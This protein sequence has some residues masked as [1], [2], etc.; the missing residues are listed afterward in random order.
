MKK[1]LTVNLN[2]I[3]FHIDNDAYDALYNY[4][5]EVENRLSEA[6]RKEVMADIE[7]R[8][9]ELFTEKLSKGKHVVTIDDVDLVISVLGKPNQFASE[10]TDNE[11]EEEPVSNH[12]PPSKKSTRK[13]YRDEDNAVLGGIAAG[14]AAYL[15]WDVATIRIILVV[16]LFLSYSTLIPVYIIVW[17]IAPAARTVAQKLEMQGEPVTAERIK[18]EINSMKNYVNS[19]EF[20][21]RS[22]SFGNRLG[23]VLRPLIKIFLGVVGTIMGFV[24]FAVLSALLFALSLMIFSPAILSGFFPEFGTLTTMLIVSILLMI[25]IPV[26]VLIFGA[27]RIISGKRS[28]NKRF[29][30]L[31]LVLW[32]IGIFLFAGM[33]GKAVVSV[34]RGDASNFSFYWDSNTYET[35][36][37]RN[38][39][40][41]DF[42]SLDV[43]GNVK[44]YLI[45]DSA[46]SL[47]ATGSTTAL[48]HLKTGLKDGV[49]KISTEKFHVNRELK[50]L[51]F[52][53]EIH[54][55]KMSG[56]STL[57]GQG[58]FVADDM[59]I[60]LNGF[61]KANLDVHVNHILTIKQLLASELTMEGMAY[62]MDPQFSGMSKFDAGNLLVRTASIKG[63]GAVE[64]N[65]SVT[66]SL[67]VDVSG[68]ARFRNR[69]RPAYLHYETQGAA[70]VKFN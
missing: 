16:L 24:G 52:A 41:G 18:E 31:L 1:T 58:K 45:Q 4:L 65:T 62:R 5:S 15:G 28:G 8:I 54:S 61:S 25:G 51:L 21:R 53:P 38:I 29:G 60:E 10:D 19:E 13:F 11:D 67:E 57:K 37:T 23:A 68:A 32:V 64:I 40:V 44:I 42:H 26:F 56:A 17:I 50:L 14:L 47:K 22:S 33:S 30:W 35:E 43:S 69:Y 55:L 70:S 49:L 59:H 6:E 2:N 9:A 27:I 63:N 66:D 46:Y 3:V 36:I 34:I 48:S 12:Q 20:E 39:S 7:A